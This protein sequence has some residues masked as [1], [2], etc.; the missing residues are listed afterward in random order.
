MAFQQIGF[1]IDGK[2]IFSLS[3]T[4]FVESDSKVQIKF[5]LDI[6]YDFFQ[7]ASAC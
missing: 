5:L 7:A 3:M 2:A 1:L 6:F 4:V